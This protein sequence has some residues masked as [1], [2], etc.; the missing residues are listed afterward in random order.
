MARTNTYTKKKI[1]VLGKPRATST[2]AS[3]DGGDTVF[4]PVDNS[5]KIVTS[6]LPLI[7]KKRNDKGLPKAAQIYKH[8]YGGIQKKQQKK[9]KRVK[10]D[11]VRSSSR[12]PTKSSG[13]RY[14]IDRLLDIRTEP[15]IQVEWKGWE[16]PT[17]EPFD[18]IL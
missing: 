8:N 10:R 1:R 13:G 7:P 14:G 16:E 17:W 12:E 3:S 2:G 11:T 5:V 4:A 6:K 15:S 9:R 18:M